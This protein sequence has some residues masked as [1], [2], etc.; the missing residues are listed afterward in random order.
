MCVYECFM[1]KSYLKTKKEELK[2]RNRRKLA[3]TIVV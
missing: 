2:Y 3:L 1:C